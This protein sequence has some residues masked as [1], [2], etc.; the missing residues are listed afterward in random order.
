VNK[1]AFILAKE[2]RHI[3]RDPRS[4]VIAILMPLLMTL[5]YGYAVNLDTENIKLAVIDS[6]HSEES[7]ALA[8]AFFRSG[9]FVPAETVPPIP[10]P[11]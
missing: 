10:N 6:D 4:L 2:F 3:L 11:S 1:T 7:R 9:Y 8:E 5:L